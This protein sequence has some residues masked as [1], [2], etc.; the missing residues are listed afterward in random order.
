M[1]V[2]A[3]QQAAN[4]LRQEYDADFAQAS[5]F[6]PACDIADEDDDESSH[7]CDLDMDYTYDPHPPVP[8]RAP[9][10]VPGQALRGRSVPTG[11][12]IIGR[13]D[14]HDLFGN[15]PFGEVA[16]SSAHRV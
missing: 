14:Q 12:K 5:D 3:R 8:S 13:F 2:I 6:V 1:E 16:S 11:R 7:S 15:S 10:I 4:E 9:R